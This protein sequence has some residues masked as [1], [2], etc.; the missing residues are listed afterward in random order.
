VWRVEQ[1]LVLVQVTVLAVQVTVLVVARELEQKSR[2][3]PERMRLT[4]SA[5]TYSGNIAQERFE[6]SPQKRRSAGPK[7]CRRIAEDFRSTRPARMAQ[8]EWHFAAAHRS[9]SEMS[10]QTCA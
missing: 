3:P 5:K 10:K 6:C 7:T 2:R 4:T 8:H 9:R 1:V